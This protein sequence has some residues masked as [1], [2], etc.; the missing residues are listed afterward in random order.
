MKTCK[1]LV[2]ILFLSLT[3]IQKDLQRR[4]GSRDDA[5]LVGERSPAEAQHACI[6]CVDGLCSPNDF[7][8][9]FRETNF[10]A[11]GVADGDDDDDGD[12][13][14]SRINDGFRLH[15]IGDLR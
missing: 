13:V 8:E 6:L 10:V 14:A 12:G 4:S 1:Q 3:W 9:T 2:T 5:H 15:G 7:T 11:A